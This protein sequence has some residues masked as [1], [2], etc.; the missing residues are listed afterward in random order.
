MSDREIGSIMGI[1]ASLV[2]QWRRR[3]RLWLKDRYSSEEEE[4]QSR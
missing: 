4:D 2:G 1:K 3:A